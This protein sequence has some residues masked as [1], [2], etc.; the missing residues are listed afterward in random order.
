MHT[1]T[2][3]INSTLQ[4]LISPE[5]IQT[6]QAYT[7][8]KGVINSRISKESQILLRVTPRIRATRCRFGDLIKLISREIGSI[9]YAL[10]VWYERCVDI[11]DSVPVDSVEELESNTRGFRIGMDTI[12]GSKG[13]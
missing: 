8:Q 11:A 5:P 2:I 1:I 4:H 9:G 10:E 13:K 6:H 7:K 12:S 3:T